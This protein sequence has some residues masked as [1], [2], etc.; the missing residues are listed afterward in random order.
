MRRD[1]QMGNRIAPAFAA[2]VTPFEVM[3][4]GA[5]KVAL[6]QLSNFC[7][8]LKT[9]VASRSDALA[10]LTDWQILCQENSP[11]GMDQVQLRRLNAG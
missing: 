5:F 4:S 3:C 6:S 9:A 11:S 2:T 8:N 1:F 10:Q 7:I